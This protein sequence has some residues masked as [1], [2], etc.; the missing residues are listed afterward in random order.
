MCNKQHQARQEWMMRNLC[1][2]W[3]QASTISQT[4]LSLHIYLNKRVLLLQDHEG[5]TLGLAVAHLGILVFQTFTKINTFSW[6]KI[7]KLSFK[8]KKFLIK[9]HPE[10]YVSYIVTLLTGIRMSNTRHT[11]CRIIEIF[12]FNFYFLL[13][14]PNI[15]HDQI[16]SSGDVSPLKL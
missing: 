6:A 5:V 4:C 12:S 10:G 15:I 13:P 14:K 7:R 11:L 3:Y 8:R 2:A 9:L 1:L 16:F